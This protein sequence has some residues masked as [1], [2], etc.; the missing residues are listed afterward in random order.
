MLQIS[1]GYAEAAADTTGIRANANKFAPPP[2]KKRGTSDRYRG[3]ATIT[4]AIRVGGGGE[5]RGL[6]KAGQEGSRLRVFI[7]QVKCAQR[8][9]TNS[10]SDFGDFSIFRHTAG[11]IVD[12]RAP[13]TYVRRR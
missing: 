8:S 2:G 7:L 3:D 4:D 9:E 5:G 13:E 12:T 11:P 1:R 10:L 6:Q